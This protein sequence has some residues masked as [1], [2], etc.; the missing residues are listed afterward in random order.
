MREWRGAH[1]THGV[2]PAEA[3]ISTAA[4]G[5]S[6]FRGN[7]TVD[8]NAHPV[9]IAGLVPAIHLPVGRPSA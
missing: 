3:G 5:D 7:D 8:R 4:Q 2:I 1:P 9:V 6:R